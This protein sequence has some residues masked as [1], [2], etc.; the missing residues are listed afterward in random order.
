MQIRETWDPRGPWQKMRRQEAINYAK[1]LGIVFDENMP[2]DIIIKRL[3]AAGAPPPKLPPRTIGMHANPRQDDTSPTSH[4]YEG[5]QDQ[6]QRE[7]V[8]VDA[9]ELAELEWMQA[10][11]TPV[12]KM[13][14]NE[15]RAEA[16][17]RGIKL[18]RKMTMNDLRALLDGK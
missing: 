8:T 10:K 16:K 15:L 14:I 3:I 7:T 5:P 11:K 4:K 2:K 6:P 17:T 18:T 12:A 9:A 13:S 1:E